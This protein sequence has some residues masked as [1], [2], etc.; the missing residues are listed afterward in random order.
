MKAGETV[1][2]HVVAEGAIDADPLL[3]GW[4]RELCFQLLKAG[5]PEGEAVKGS[6]EDCGRQ[7]IRLVPGIGQRRGSGS[8]VEY[9]VE[10]AGQGGQFVHRP[11]LLS[12]KCKKESMRCDAAPT[13]GIRYPFRLRLRSWARSRRSNSRL[14]SEIFSMWSFSLW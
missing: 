4:Q 10:I 14:I 11:I 13:P 7:D 2:Q 8:E 6:Q 3:Q 5:Q 12:H 1:A 9:F